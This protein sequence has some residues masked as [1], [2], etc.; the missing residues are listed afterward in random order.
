MIAQIIKE[1]PTPTTQFGEPTYFK[2][3]TPAQSV[4]T[5]V[6]SAIELYDLIRMLDAPD[7]PHAFIE[8]GNFRIELQDAVFKENGVVEAKAV[9]TEK[10]K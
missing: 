8:V 5:S 6:R 7:Y 10:P 4:I 1:W 2:R 3:R 9:I